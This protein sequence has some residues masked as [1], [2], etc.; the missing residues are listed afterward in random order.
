M[1]HIRSLRPAL[2]EGEKVKLSINA[3][4]ENF[5]VRMNSQEAGIE[6]LWTL[7]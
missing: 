4:F 2:Q 7:S 1:I 3:A 6:G 5:I